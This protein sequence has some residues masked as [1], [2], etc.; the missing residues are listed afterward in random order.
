MT[1]KA[2]RTTRGARVLHAHHVLLAAIYTLAGGSSAEAR[3]VTTHFAPN[4]SCVNGYWREGACTCDPCWEGDACQHY[5]DHYGPQFLVHEAT[6]VLPANVT[7]IA[8]HAWSID[9]DLGLT[10]PLGPGE[11]ARC[12]CAVVQYHL[13]AA[14]GDVHFLLDRDTGIIT[15]NPQSILAP[16]STYA[17]QLMVQDVP[18]GSE[19]SAGHFDILDLKIYVSDDHVRKIPWT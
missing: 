7:G 19:M 5:A 14:P 6:V 17:Y 16:G 15:R 18:L 11:S 4:N 13:F 1:S 2:C 3:S 12:P 8:Y 10:C 9:E